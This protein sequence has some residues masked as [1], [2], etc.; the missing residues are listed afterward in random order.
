MDT[1]Y[2]V[3]LDVHKRMISYCVKESGGKI[4]AEGSIPATRLELDRWLKT[5]DSAAPRNQRP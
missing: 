3:G 4:H 1:R 5:L 2:Y